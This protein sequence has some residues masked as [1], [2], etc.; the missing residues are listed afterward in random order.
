MTNDGLTPLDRTS[1]RFAA[2]VEQQDWERADQYAALVFELVG[3][4]APA[5]V[6][7]SEEDRRGS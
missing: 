5:K 2:A 6:P 1:A 4:Q 7:P 3:R